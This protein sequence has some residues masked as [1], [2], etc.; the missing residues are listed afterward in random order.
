MEA[1]VKVLGHALHQML[2]VL[3]LG[4]L[5][6]AVLFD[7][8]HLATGGE[9]WAL[10]SYW[11]IALGVASGLLAAVFGFA[12]WTKIP[13]ETR[14]KRV[15]RAHGLGNVVVLLLFTV[16]WLL[17]RDSVVDPGMLPVVLSLAGGW[18]A[19][20]TGWLGGEMVDRLGV[21]VDDGAHLD[22][23]SSISGHPA[24]VRSATSERG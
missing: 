20:L 5:T 4:T 8:C 14:A 22:A 7:L 6:G 10:V 1:R 17:R 16:S 15:G 18:L 21:G 23:P 19:M 9:Q 2:I 3:P 12:D 24:T 13:R 11:L